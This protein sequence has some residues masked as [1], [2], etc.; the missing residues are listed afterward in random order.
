MADEDNAAHLA[1]RGRDWQAEFTG[2]QYGGRGADL[3]RKAGGRYDLGQIVSDRLNHFSS[4]HP[5]AD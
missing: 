3:D 4:P 5:Q 2:Q 1:V